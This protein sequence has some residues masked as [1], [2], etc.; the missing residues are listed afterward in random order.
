[1]PPPEPKRLALAQPQGQCDAPPGAVPLGRGQPE[2]PQRFIESQRLNL[3]VAG[4][5]GVNQGGD[6][7]GDV[8]ALHGDLQSTRQDAVNLEHRGGCQAFSFQ[9]GV[10]ALDVLG[11]EPVRFQEC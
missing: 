4:R 9:A 11:G 6:I 2:N 7:A 1:M 8:S 5:R 3:V 10:E